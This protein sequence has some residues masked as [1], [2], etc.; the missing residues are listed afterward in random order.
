MS[1]SRSRIREP[2]LNGK[3]LRLRP[4]GGIPDDNPFRGSPVWSVGHRN[5]QGLAWDAAGRLWEVELGQ[6]RFDEVNLIRPGRT[7]GGRG[8]RARGGTDGG[9]YTNPLVTWPTSARV[10]ERRAAGRPRHRIVR[11]AVAGSR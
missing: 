6:D 7:T 1:S 9:R 3:I 2:R 8:S 10:A 11:V 5:V 4:D